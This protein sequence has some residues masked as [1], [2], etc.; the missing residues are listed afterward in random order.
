MMIYFSF[1]IQFGVRLLV[2][3]DPM[4]V[5]LPRWWWR[6]ERDDLYHGTS[7]V[8]CCGIRFYLSEEKS[9]GNKMLASILS[10]NRTMIIDGVKRM[11]G[12]ML[13]CVQFT[14]QART[15]RQ[16]LMG[17]LLTGVVD[18]FCPSVDLPRLLARLLARLQVTT[19]IRERVD[20]SNSIARLSGAM[21]ER[22]RYN[23]LFYDWKRLTDSSTYDGHSSA[24]P[25]ARTTLQ[26][27][28]RTGVCTRDRGASWSPTRASYRAKSSNKRLFKYKQIY[29]LFFV[30]FND[31]R[32]SMCHNVK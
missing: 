21:T 4:R 7:D 18:S 2:S 8:Y 22:E 20:V 28:R 29:I 27:A 26:L 23:R 32:E 1:P 16:A 30:I 17:C 25:A 12:R 11:V 24:V 5:L 19:H 10:I 9:I 31:I 14:H 13:E 15:K 6:W 3:I